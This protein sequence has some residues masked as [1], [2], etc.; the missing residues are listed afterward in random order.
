M[1]PIYKKRTT[2]QKRLRKLHKKLQ[3][4]KQQANHV[5]GVSGVVLAI[6]SRTVG[7]SGVVLAVVSKTVG[8][9]G[10]VFKNGLSFGVV[11]VN[12]LN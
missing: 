10:V 8:V 3:F 12:D 11:F 6:V 7:V 2:K 1:V 9:S 4:R 5:F